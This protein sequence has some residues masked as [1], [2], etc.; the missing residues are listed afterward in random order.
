MDDKFEL[1]LIRV[2]PR[3]SAEKNF[4]LAQL[5]RIDLISPGAYSHFHFAR[6]QPAPR[7]RDRPHN[8]LRDAWYCRVSQHEIKNTKALPRGVNVY[9]R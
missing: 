8:I 7:G 9:E 3:K 5:L 2:P 4:A 6:R 1:S